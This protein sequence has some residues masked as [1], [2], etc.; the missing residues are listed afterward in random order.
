MQPR[1]FFLPVL[2]AFNLVSQAQTLPALPVSPAPVVNYEYDAN[3][4]PTKTVRGPGGLNLTT[5]ND[6]DTL[7]RVQNSIDPKIAQTRLTYDGLDR[8]TKVTDPRTLNTQFVRNGFGWITQILSPDTGTTNFTYDT[9]GNLLTRTDASGAVASMTY[10]AE[11]RIKTLSYSKS[12]VAAHSYA[13]TYDQTGSGF[14]RGIGRLTTITYPQGS[15]QYAYDALGH[16]IK[17][18]Q[19][20]GSISQA[21]TYGWD[22]S[23]QLASITYPSGRVVSMGYGNGQITSIGLAPNGSSQA[24]ALLNQIAYQPF[25]PVKAWQWQMAATTKAHTLQYDLSGRMVRYPLGGIVRDLTYDAANRITSFTHYDASTGTATATAKAMNQTFGYDANSQLTST[26]SQATTW[27]ATYDANGNR[28]ST[29]QNGVTRNYAVPSSSNRLTS[30]SSGP[31][32]SFSY[33]VNGS[34]TGDSARYTAATY[35]PGET[36]IATLQIGSTTKASYD[37]NNLSQRIRKT[38]TVGTNAPVITLFVYDQAGH[39]L[40]EYDGTG[41]ALYEYVWLYDTPV[42]M[43]KPDP[44]SASNPPLVYYIDTDH[45]S[46]PRVVFDRSGKRRW[47]WAGDPFGAGPGPED[48]NPEG[49]GTFA[50][51]LRMPGQYIDRESGL[52]YNWNRYYDPSTGRYIQFDP[53]GLMGGSMSPYVYVNGNPLSFFDPTGTDRWGAETAPAVVLTFQKE[54]RTLFYDPAAERMFSIPTNSA[55]ASSSKPGA[56][57]PYSGL[58]TMCQR[59]KLGKAY[60]T[61]KLRTTDSRS[62]WVHGGGSRSPNPYA[63]EQGWYPTE[64][65]TRAQNQDIEDLCTAVEEY[66]DQHSNPVILYRRD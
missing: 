5:I 46:T 51:N 56:S 36:Q 16:V 33:D 50:F 23:G 12:G 54:G 24:Q 28:T 52:F 15:T 63:P 7:D 19:K 17:A 42:A 14:S 20:V 34:A 26:V 25:G 6:Y 37:Y 47:E 8:P 13:W 38:V 1:F 9:V 29:T 61:A 22:S 4:N 60:G 11:D 30:I 59:G 43:F 21:V 2:L 32:Q 64:G 41:K 55:V 44:A 65:C 31:Y 39:L 40:G 10:D 35:S 57:G 66:Q 53:I 3:G 48:A 58:V 62:R 27:S 18:T 45:L 49:L